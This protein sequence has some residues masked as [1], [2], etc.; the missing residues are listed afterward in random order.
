MRPAPEIGVVV[1]CGP[2]AAPAL[3]SFEA[4]PEAGHR[5]GSIWAVATVGAPEAGRIAKT[6]GLD[7]VVTAEVGE[8]AAD[9]LNRGVRAA[10]AAGA[11]YL[12]LLEAGCVLAPGALST[13]LI[14][15]EAQPK[16]GA[17]CPALVGDDGL[18]QTCGGSF[19]PL[20]GRTGPRRRGADPRSFGERSWECADFA[21]SA[22]I[23][24]KRE[25]LE[26]VGLFHGA[27]GST[28]Y[29]AELGLRAK[30]EYWTVLA[31]PQARASAPAEVEERGEE[32]ARERARTP[33]WLL[34]A[35][36]TPVKRLTALP[37]AAAWSWPLAC[38]KHVA[39]GRFRCAGA[40]V[41]G[42]W[43]GLF[44]SRWRD[45]IHLAVP[46]QGRR[47]RLQ[48]PSTVREMARYF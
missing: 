37:L 35:W 3:R 18:V 6:F 48:V 13:L 33:F 15:L 4:L 7:R 2:E 24:L 47:V 46:L 14:A 38:A 34:R 23:L 39:G 30:R 27:Y 25:L 19:N 9:R 36:G 17:V 21:P 32:V 29:D 40:V 43:E 28:G 42:S 20:T 8:G 12:L 22:C 44:G 31:V 45:G 5:A 11:D 41:R 1:L 16:A 10:L 26:D